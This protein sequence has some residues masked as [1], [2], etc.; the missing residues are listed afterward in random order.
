[1]T[2]NLLL[3]IATFIIIG[4]IIS[5][6][7][8]NNEGVVIDKIPQDFHSKYGI[9]P[10]TIPEKVQFAGEDVPLNNFD[11]HESLDREILIN[12][13]WQSQ[14]LIFIKRCNKYFPII[15]PILKE[16]GIPDDFKYLAVAESGLANATSSAGAKGF[17]QFL[18]GTAGDYKLEVNNEVDERYDVAKSTHAACKYFKESYAKYGSWSMTAA[19]YNMGRRN[20]YQQISRQKTKNYYDLVLSEETAR[21]V[22]RI[23]ALKLILE[24]PSN[25]GFYVKK[26]EMYTPV[27]YKTVE[28]DTAIQHLADFAHTMSINYKV[29]K[30]LNPWLRENKLSNL[31]RKTYKIKIPKEGYRE[32]LPN[33][34]FYPEDSLLQIK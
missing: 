21:Y 22:Y 33:T 18:K 15:E 4:F 17:W 24:S 30:E 11:A 25:Y 34:D 16:N 31:K 19:S 28:V 32:I 13:Y 20:T 8:N 10:V 7:S 14:T 6:F 5:S 12:T 1:M 23:I 26:D 3:G 29:L 27:P 9:F 2:K